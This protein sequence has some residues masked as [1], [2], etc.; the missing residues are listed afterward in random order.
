MDSGA[1][2]ANRG[3]VDSGVWDIYDAPQLGWAAFVWGYALAWFLVTD[4]VKLLAYRILD[5][6]KPFKISTP[7]DLTPQIAK[8]A[9]ELYEQQGRRDG[10]SSQDWLEA[11]REIRKR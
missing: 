1:W 4:R 7:F 6:I 8:R 9:Y 5:P 3:D 2:H 11:E 10:H